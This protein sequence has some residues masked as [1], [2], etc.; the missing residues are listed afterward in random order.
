MYKFKIRLVVVLLFEWGA[1]MIVNSRENTNVYLPRIGNLRWNVEEISRKESSI[2]IIN[3]SI[4][5]L[6][7]YHNR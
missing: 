3:P 2:P 7:S 1:F 6:H 4:V 5:R